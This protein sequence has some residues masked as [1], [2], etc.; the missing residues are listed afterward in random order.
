M[1]TTSPLDLA[2]AKVAALTEFEV[3]EQLRL[4]H[5]AFS[6]RFP[7]DHLASADDFDA[8]MPDATA[9]GRPPGAP[10]DTLT[11]VVT[12]LCDT[13]VASA[14]PDRF[15]GLPHTW[16]GPLASAQANRPWPP[17]VLGYDLYTGRVGP[18]LA[19]AA[20]DRVLDNPTYH[21][22]AVQIFSATAEGLSDPPSH[23]QPETSN[24]WQK[25]PFSAYA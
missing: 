4:I 9:G 5:S 2:A 1:L 25:A 23:P 21:D 14:L 7:D 6:C 16:I 19:L 11:G 18:A 12:R 13:L 17:A 10:G 15:A 3:G 8:P 20:A 22:L 24:A